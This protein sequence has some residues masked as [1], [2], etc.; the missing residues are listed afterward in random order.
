MG[1]LPTE[2]DSKTAEKQPS[3]LWNL[4]FNLAL[5]TIILTKLSAE[6]YLG[7]KLAIVIAL[8]FPLGYGLRDLVVAKK[9]NFFSALGIVSIGLTGGI[10]LM[11]LD[12]SY[13]AMKEAAIP[14][15]LGI[16]TLVSLK[17]SQPL[18][19]TFLLNDAVVNT[20]SVSQ[21]LT[22]NNAHHDFNKLLLNASL[23]L[24]GSF[25]LSALLNYILA[26]VILTADPGTELF[27]Q[28]LGKM[29][30]LSFPVIALPLTVIL[31]ANL[32]YIFRGISRLTNL[33]MEQLL[34]KK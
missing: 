28:Q 24:S 6:N 12:A 2:N 11:E 21:A 8:S 19:H 10:S 32:L 20:Q 16:A 26:V 30:A 25:F 33:S 14:A 15:M 18:V 7:I 29:T 4:I 22:A 9:I 3:L 1:S 31:S 5:P 34:T 17:T 13:I 27:N 23:F